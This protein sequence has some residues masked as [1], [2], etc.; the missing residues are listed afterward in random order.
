MPTF[1]RLGLPVA[2]AAAVLACAALAHA[3]VPMTPQQRTEISALAKTALGADEAASAKAV[4]ALKAMGEVARPRL[5]AVVTE[6]LQRGRTLV[7]GAGKRISDP[8]KVRQLEDEIEA[9]RVKARDNIK[10]LEKGEPVR[11]AH[12]YYDALEPKLALFKDVYVI[13]NAIR[14]EMARRPAL[15]ALYQE[16]GG[17]DKRLTPEMEAKL[18]TDAEALLGLTLAQAAEI[19]AFAAGAGPAESPQRHYWFYDACRRIEAY[20][21]TLESLMS[22]GEVDNLKTLNAYREMLGTLPVEADARLLQAARRHSK[23]MVEKGYFAHESP[24]PSEKSHAQRMQNAGYDR[25]YSEN[26]A[27]GS[28]SGTSTFWQW[29]DSPGHHKNMVHEG[30]TGFGIGQWAST[31]TQNFGT[32]ARLMLKEPEDRAKAVVKGDIVEPRGAGGSR[33]GT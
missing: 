1:R 20:N 3:A 32:G 8:A 11:L 4:D 23:E 30:S 13:R 24:T 17:D 18:K 31:W 22:G 6:L 26:I 16:V 28:T 33:R 9:L 12:E 15:Y 7:T 14:H 10:V 19:P 21:A 29:F 5:K 25:P 27:A 2:L